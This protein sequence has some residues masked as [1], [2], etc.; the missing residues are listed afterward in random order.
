MIT[1]R[2]LMCTLVASVLAFCAA[3]GVASEAR[4][5]SYAWPF[6]VHT[7]FTWPLTGTTPVSG[8]IW[9]SGGGSA[10]KVIE[11]ESGEH[12]PYRKGSEAFPQAGAIWS[13]VAPLK[14]NTTYQASFIPTEDNEQYA[15]TYGDPIVFTTTASGVLPPPPAPPQQVRYYRHTHERI[16]RD[17]AACNEDP[18]HNTRRYLDVSISPDDQG[19][20]RVLEVV[21]YDYLDVHPDGYTRQSHVY[22]G[23]NTQRFVWLADEDTPQDDPCVAV[24]MIDMYGQRSDTVTVCEP[25]RCLQQDRLGPFEDEDFTLAQCGLNQAADELLV[26]CATPA[27]QRSPRNAP[28]AVLMVLALGAAWRRRATS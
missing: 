1:T 4:A 20:P 17:S 24:T 23:E 16:E 10:I 11:V 7:D 9:A 12:V 28:W 3:F 13:P 19:H 21:Y 25:D 18:T 22:A 14:P 15:Y 26:G 5:C 2:S 27:H 6:R 8:Q